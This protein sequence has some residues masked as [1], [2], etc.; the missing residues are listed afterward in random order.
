MLKPRLEELWYWVRERESIRRK[1][2]A[3]ERPPWTKDPILS[4]YRFCNVRREDDKVTR[5]IADEIR[6]PYSTHPHLWLMLCIARQINLPAT[7]G[8]LIS[9]ERAWP[10]HSKFS[11]AKLGKVMDA[12]RD[13][14]DQVYTGAY[15]IRA[16]S[17]KSAPW[18][19][20]TKQWYL[21][22]I[23]IGKLWQDR[24]KFDPFP[25]TLQE[26]HERLLKYRGWGPFMAYQAVVDMRFT[27]LLNRAPDRGTWACMGPGTKRGLNRLSG[28][29]VDA[30]LSQ[31]EGLKEILELYHHPERPKDIP[32]DLS[33]VPNI[34]CEYDKWVRVKS[35]EGRPRST[36]TPRGS[37]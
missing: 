34:C 30:P 22:R 27:N 3:G 21:A 29:A 16:E 15:M 1:R 35:G 8:E 37:A 33:D 7:L 32:M 36:Y 10:S 5:W 26:T 14:G 31:E 19:N 25:T 6:G 17:D 2:L 9:T 18:F 20:E 23:V 13:R 4:A 28:R 12:R 24:R 11:P